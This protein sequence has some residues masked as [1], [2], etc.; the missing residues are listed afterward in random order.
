MDFTKLISEEI[1]T[2]GFP[3]VVMLLLPWREDST[4]KEVEYLME[5]LHTSSRW[6]I[7]VHNVSYRMNGNM[8]TKIH[9]HGRYIILI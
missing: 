8:Y 6:P 7:M 3:P 1:F 4:N 2:P 5:E 9:P